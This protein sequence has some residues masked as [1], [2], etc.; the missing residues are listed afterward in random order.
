M[1]HPDIPPKSKSAEDEQFERLAAR[2]EAASDRDDVRAP[3]R[4]KS[5][6]YS[7]LME[8]SE[9]PLRVLQDTKEAGHGLCV[10]EEIARVSRVGAGAQ[11]FNY[12]RICHGRIFSE[13]V[14][15]A[16]IFWNN[17]PYAA[18]QNR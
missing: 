3:T 15:N 13:R 2:S 14:E 7:E 1:K 17:C 18:F 11:S 5:K 8:R 16:P 10:F 4:L 9:G 6:I 12:C